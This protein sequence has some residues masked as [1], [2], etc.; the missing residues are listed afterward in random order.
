MHDYERTMALNYFA[1]LRLTLAL[2]PHMR[3]QGG[4]RVVNVSSIGAEHAST[5]YG[6]AKAAD[7]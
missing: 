6:A 3:A 2:L 4:G 5:S 1:P 7:L